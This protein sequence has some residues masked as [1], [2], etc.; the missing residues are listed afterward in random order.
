MYFLE[1]LYL[2]IFLLK[3]KNNTFVYKVTTM[4]C[5]ISQRV[6]ICSRRHVSLSDHVPNQGI[7]I[8]QPRLSFLRLFMEPEPQALIV[9]I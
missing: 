7:D 8:S 4:C 2:F 6:G 1:K 5:L 3:C 9:M